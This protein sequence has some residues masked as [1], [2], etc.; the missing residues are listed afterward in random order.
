MVSGEQG[1]TNPY[2]A[3]Q[4]GPQTLPASFS[5][6]HIYVVSRTES[7]A[8]TLMDG[9]LKFWR[10]SPHIHG[11]A[12]IGGAFDIDDCGS[13]GEWCVRESAYVDTV[14]TGN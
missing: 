10:G 7:Y 5:R 13:V 11:R 4:T 9:R 8:C 6:H 14:D 3:Y 12:W 2:L 1:A